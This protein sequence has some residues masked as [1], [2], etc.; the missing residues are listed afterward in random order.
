MKELD[1]N[2]VILYLKNIIDLEVAKSMLLKQYNIEKS[3]S[4]KKI[5][6]IDQQRYL[7][8][9]PVTYD[10]GKPDEFSFNN[11]SETSFG[12]ATIG[13]FVGLMCVFVSFFSSSDSV[14]D[15]S[16]IPR[17]FLIL[18]IVFILLGVIPIVKYFIAYNRAKKDY[19]RYVSDWN[20][21]YGSKEYINAQLEK[22]RS[23]NEEIWKKKEAVPA[24]VK[25][26]KAQWT[27]RNN[28][29]AREWEKINAILE[30]F[31]SMNIIP[32]QYRRN[33]SATFWIYDWMSSS[34]ESLS[35]TLLHAHIEDG[36]RRIERKLDMLT[37]KVEDQIQQTRLI[38]SKASTIIA[39]N[40]NMLNHLQ[41]TEK[42]AE[43][44]AQYSQLAANYSKANA[45]F[46][47]ATYLNTANKK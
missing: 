2:A 14:N 3:N 27:K 9:Y 28:Y 46:S 1:R 37:S 45:Y 5:Q 40:K 6:A 38:E 10:P 42:N 19:D 35:S 34:Q 20:A 18:G 41:Q 32:N 21:T 15:N 26:A 36:I 22:I 30:G 12:L 7:P 23:K 43:L 39:Q 16:Q 24:Q 29:Y 4:E 8:L 13:L 17:I 11:G 31:Y 44:S 25:A 47:L 33:L